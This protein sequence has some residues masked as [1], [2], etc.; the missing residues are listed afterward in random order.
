MV[1][2]EDQSRSCDGKI[3]EK[4]FPKSN[5][6]RISGRGRGNEAKANQKHNLTGRRG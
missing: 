1:Q 6:N 2:E 3:K 5:K 4:Q